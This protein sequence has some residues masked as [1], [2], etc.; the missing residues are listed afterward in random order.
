MGLIT[1]AIVSSILEL[2]STWRPSGSCEIIVSV[3]VAGHHYVVLLADL[4]GSQ[5]MHS[6]TEFECGSFLL[7]NNWANEV[8]FNNNGF[9]SLHRV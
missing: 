7:G 6:M 8:L 5:Q 2:K 3:S 9:L 1:K 4:C